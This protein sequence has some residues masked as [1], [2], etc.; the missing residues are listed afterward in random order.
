MDKLTEHINQ[1]TETVNKLNKDIQALTYIN[2]LLT[3]IMFES[4]PQFKILAADILEQTAENSDID[5]DKFF[6][7]LESLLKCS[8]SPTRLTSAGRRKWIRLVSQSESD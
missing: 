6:E 7:I 4:N 2:H 8:R 1:L 3:E 5:N